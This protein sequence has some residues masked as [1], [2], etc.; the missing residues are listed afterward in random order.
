MGPRVREDDH[1]VFG[2]ALRNFPIQISNSHG[3]SFSRRNASE[4]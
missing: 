2:G 4:V 3:F 1:G